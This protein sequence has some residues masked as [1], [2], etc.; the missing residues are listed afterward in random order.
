MAHPAN[1]VAGSLE[2]GASNAEFRAMMIIAGLFQGG[3]ITRQVQQSMINYETG[4]HD[5]ADSLFRVAVDGVRSITTTVNGSADRVLVHAG[6][7]IL[8]TDP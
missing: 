7:G 4:S 1:L 6:V 8:H 5:L 2:L 3:T